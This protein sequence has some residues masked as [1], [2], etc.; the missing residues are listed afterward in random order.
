MQWQ[1]LCQLSYGR[2]K[3]EVGVVDRKRI[4]RGTQREY[5]FS[6]QWLRH[7][8]FC[9]PSPLCSLSL[10]LSL[11]RYVFCLIVVFAF[12]KWQIGWDCMFGCAICAHHSWMW[13]CVV[14][15]V[16]QILSVPLQFIVC[17]IG[18]VSIK[19]SMLLFLFLPNQSWIYLIRRNL[20]SVFVAKSTN[21][22]H[23]TCLCAQ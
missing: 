15:K 4:C 21:T 19:F 17:L 18:Y 7:F 16:V 9:P 13:L 11:S 1:Q 14:L 8:V 23:S 10:S 5:P 2:L 3:S 6:S 22:F 12:V 20:Y